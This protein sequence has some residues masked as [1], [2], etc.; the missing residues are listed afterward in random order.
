MK[1]H[2]FGVEIAAALGVNAA[3]IF[4]HVAYWTDK[5]LAQGKNIG[6]GKAWIYTSA[7]A[8]ANLYPYLSVTQIRTALKKLKE[9]GLIYDGGP[10]YSDSFG[11]ATAYTLT[12]KGESLYYI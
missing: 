6:N 4:D 9:A 8:L 2:H 11:R 5:N 12:T 10:V 3:L 1:Y 7:P